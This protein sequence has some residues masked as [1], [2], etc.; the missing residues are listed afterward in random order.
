MYV[1]TIKENNGLFWPLFISAVL[2]QVHHQPDT[3]DRVP[4]DVSDPQGEWHASDQKPTLSY[5]SACLPDKVCKHLCYCL[6][7]ANW[8][9]FFLQAKSSSG[10]PTSGP[11]LRLCWMRSVQ[12]K[13]MSLLEVN[14]NQIRPRQTE[15]ARGLSGVTAMFFVGWGSKGFV[16]ELFSRCDQEGWVELLWEVISQGSNRGA[17][18]S[19]ERSSVDS[20]LRFLTALCSPGWH[21]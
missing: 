16:S 2:L 14:E 9:A 21:K 20:S 19:I 7:T 18:R 17:P 13:T 6:D 12:A 1:T 11:C 10:C 15:P 3:A 8:N 4:P 5:A